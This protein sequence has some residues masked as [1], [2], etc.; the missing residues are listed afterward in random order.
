MPRPNAIKY[1][2]ASDTFGHDAPEIFFRAG[3]RS[4]RSVSFTTRCVELEVAVACK[5]ASRPCDRRAADARRAISATTSRASTPAI[6]EADGESYSS[7]RAAESSPG[8]TVCFGAVEI[9]AGRGSSSSSSV[10]DSCSATARLRTRCFRAVS[11]WQKNLTAKLRIL[12]RT[13]HRLKRL[14][15]I[16]PHFA[17][18]N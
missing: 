5:E 1:Q 14:H 2:H 8:A 17:R 10:Q 12:I 4:A 16:E 18:S 13:Q 9:K 3:C 11:L 7:D 6:A 15:V